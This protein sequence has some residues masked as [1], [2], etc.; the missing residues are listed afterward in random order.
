MIRLAYACGTGGGGGKFI[1]SVELLTSVHFCE[2]GVLG[3]GFI[4]FGHALD[5]SLWLKQ[6]LLNMQK[7]FS[8]I[9]GI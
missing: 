4:W 1:V 5:P 3:V 6:S 2:W 7:H 9:G 8:F